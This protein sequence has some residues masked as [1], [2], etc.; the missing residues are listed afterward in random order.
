MVIVNKLAQLCND[1]EMLSPESDKYELKIQEIIHE[2]GTHGVTNPDTFESSISDIVNGGAP[3][4]AVFKKSKPVK[5][6]PVV[7]AKELIQESKPKVAKKK[8]TKKKSVKK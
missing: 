2:L 1:L 5:S 7:T 3:V 8:T 4:P 6:D